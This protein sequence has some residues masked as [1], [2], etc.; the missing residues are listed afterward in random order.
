MTTPNILALTS[1][2]PTVLVSTRI[3]V[4]TDSA[5][6]TVA[7]NRAVKLAQGSLCNMTASAVVVGLSIVPAGGTVGDGTHKIIPDTYSLGAGDTLPLG[8]YLADHVL[9]DGDIIAM[10]CGTADA[11]DVVISGVVMA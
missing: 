2:T 10:H 1:M 9:G 7:A 6:Y 11:I 5:I 4:T 8:A 3:A